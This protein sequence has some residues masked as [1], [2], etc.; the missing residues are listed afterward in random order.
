MLKVAYDSC[1]WQL[2]DSIYCTCGHNH[3][4]RVIPISC[5]QGKKRHWLRINFWKYLWTEKWIFMDWKVVEVFSLL[6]ELQQISEIFPF[7]HKHCRILICVELQTHC[8]GSF[9]F[10]SKKNYFTNV[11]SNNWSSPFEIAAHH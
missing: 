10:R 3:W 11:V 5:I 2:M 6:S 7:P 4:R 8:F 9:F 1:W